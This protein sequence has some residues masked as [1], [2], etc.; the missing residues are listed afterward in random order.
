MVRM[1][2]GL[3]YRRI[4]TDTSRDTREHWRASKSVI[5]NVIDIAGCVG[6]RMVTALPFDGFLAVKDPRAD[7][8]CTTRG[9]VGV[10]TKQNCGCGVYFE[11]VCDIDTTVADTFWPDRG[12][13]SL[14]IELDTGYS[15]WFCD[16]ESKE[17]TEHRG[18]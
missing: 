14:Q 11:F 12:Y 10:C 18:G 3:E 4:R 7:R 17:T 13:F 8:R 1:V 6:T 16:I 15:Y 9:G 2:I 5:D